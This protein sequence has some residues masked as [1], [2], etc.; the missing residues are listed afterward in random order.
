MKKRFSVKLRLISAFSTILVLSG[1]T[2]LFGIVSVVQLGGIINKLFNQTN[3]VS[4]S[5]L[6]AQYQLSEIGSALKDI[7]IYNDIDNNL[8]RINACSAEVTASLDE[9]EQNFGHSDMV[10]VS[11]ESLN[12]FLSTSVSGMELIKAGDMEKGMAMVPHIKE[13]FA[14]TEESLKL[15]AQEASVSSGEIAASSER[16][17]KIAYII[18]VSLFLITSGLGTIIE[19]KTERSVVRPVNHLNDI[20]KRVAAG[21]LDVQVKNERNDELGD[22][23]LSFANMAAYLKK[24][25]ND[26][27]SQLD[28]MSTGN[29]DVSPGAEYIGCYSDIRNSLNKINDRL[30]D[31]LSQINTGAEQ[32]AAGTEHVSIGA[33]ALATGATEQAA[34]VEEL[35]SSIIEIS[36]QIRETARNAREADEIT[37]RS[38]ADISSG[39][40]QME[41]MIVSIS[42]I[43]NMSSEIG[44]IIKTIDDIA[45]Q[46][47]ILALNAAVEAARAGEAGKGFA[48][49]ADEVRNLAQKSAGAAKNTTALIEGTVAAVDKGTRIAD[50]TAK[51]LNTII[52][53]T[54]RVSQLVMRIADASERQSEAVDQVTIGVSQISQVVQTNSATSE[55]SASASE[56]LFSQA[57]MLRDLVSTFKLRSRE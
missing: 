5:A 47:N 44:K 52:D 55:E 9:I 20:A 15:I 51:S 22:L 19:V 40:Q 39:S 36:G 27:D 31:T 10:N 24:V 37:K 6:Y 29:F 38:S 28:E 49:V 43:S 32:V 1:L 18:L 14:Q 48:V 11:R 35:S 26:I 41:Q 13:L 7:L 45:F 8:K 50:D 57:Q 34:A 53:T 17:T 21:D 12:E 33:Q 42:E 2:V 54:Q 56:E 46:T 23:A 25:I 4:C 16:A 3:K 30:T